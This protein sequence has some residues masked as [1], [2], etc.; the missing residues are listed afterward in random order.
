METPK[1]SY[2][3][4]LGDRGSA[5]WDP[6]CVAAVDELVGH[7]DNIPL[8]KAYEAFLYRVKIMMQHTWHTSN[9]YEIQHVRA[10]ADQ[11]GFEVP[12]ELPSVFSYDT[13]KFTEVTNTILSSHGVDG[14]TFRGKSLAVL[15]T[16]FEALELGNVVMTTVETGNKFQLDSPTGVSSAFFRVNWDAVLQDDESED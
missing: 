3:N 15:Q 6:Q 9:I 7:T 16:V 1:K 13:N 14:V 5:H 11:M 10:A 8:V 2:F 4:L 12:Q